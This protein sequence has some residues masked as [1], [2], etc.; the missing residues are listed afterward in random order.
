MLFEKNHF[1]FLQFRDT[2]LDTAPLEEKY[3]ITLPPIYRSFISVFKPFL[4]Q[5]VVKLDDG[6]I[7]GIGYPFYS[8]TAKEMLTDD[9]EELALEGFMSVEEVLSYPRSNE[10]YL[11]GY[12][13]IA[14]HGYAGGL[15]LGIT[16]ENRDKIFHNTD[17]TI[18]TYMAENIFELIQRMHLMTS[19]LPW[20]KPHIEPVTLYQNFGEGFWRIR[21][22][23]N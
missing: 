13:F 14:N 6:T 1:P 23:K 20:Y 5:V 10:D 8:K 9:H 16:G 7:R 2:V 3:G 15:L 11:E 18:I 17:T 21:E 4:G 22:D 12:L 19:H